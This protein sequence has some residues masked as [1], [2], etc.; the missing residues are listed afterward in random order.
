MKKAAHQAAFSI[1]VEVVLD[2][3]LHLENGRPVSI[4]K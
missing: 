3:E 4:G 1:F 2:T